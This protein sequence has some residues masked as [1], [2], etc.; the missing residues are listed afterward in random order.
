I[1]ISNDSAYELDETIAITLSNVVG[2]ATLG[3][4]SATLTITDDDI[5]V[6]GTL[7]LS[8][9]TYS[10]SESGATATITVTRTGGSD[11]TVSVNYATTD[12]SATAGSD[13]TSASGTLSW[14]HGDS[15]AKTFAITISD[16][17][18]YEPSELVSLGLS[19]VTGGATLGISSGTL[20]I[21]DNDAV[22]GTLSLNNTAYTVAENG[23][24]ATITVSRTGGSDGAVSVGYTTSN[25]TATAGS[26]FTTTSGTLSW[27]NGVS[28]D[29]TFD[30]PITDDAV[31]ESDETVMISL[32]TFTG[33]ATAG[34]SS[35][36]LNITND[37]PLPNAAPNTPTLISLANN[38]V[39]VDGSSVTF[40]WNRVTDP[41]GDTVSYQLHYCTDAGFTTG[42][43]SPPV[44]ASFSMQGLLGGGMGL[45]ILGMVAAGNRRQRLIQT[46]AMMT[47]VLI[48]SACGG[49]PEAEPPAANSSV[50][51][52]T[53]AGLAPGTTYFWK[54]VASD[55][56]G[57]SSES[58]VR[59]FTTIN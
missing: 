5:A 22:P 34:T 35:A 49:E 31:Y 55:G 29:M 13:Y 20:T 54:V 43:G 8:P 2:G 19:A 36:T 6:P 24:S 39:G 56:N 32:N 14:L 33:G 41:D 42:C 21:T 12:D 17:G 9:A 58:E 3:T 48:L 37:D 25:G 1:A 28:G 52:Q 45:A 11:A 46:V 40:E 30:I 44:V 18:S 50:A 16:D 38:S 51:S 57:G 4:S 15:A 26:D 7:A 47:M 53:V 59:S 27:G 10:V 23:T